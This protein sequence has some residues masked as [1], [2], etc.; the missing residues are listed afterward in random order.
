LYSISKTYFATPALALPRSDTHIARYRHP[1]SPT[2]PNAVALPY[3]DPVLR[4]LESPIG[5]SDALGG[6]CH[7]LLVHPRD[8]ERESTSRWNRV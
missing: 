5:D 2:S 6:W 8:Y 4:L 7:R 3:R 1:P